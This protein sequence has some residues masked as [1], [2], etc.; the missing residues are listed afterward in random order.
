MRQRLIWLKNLS[1]LQAGR[2]VFN[3]TH[4][5]ELL[6]RRQLA[7]NP[8]AGL[9]DFCRYGLRIHARA[10]AGGGAGSEQADALGV[11]VFTEKDCARLHR[12][13]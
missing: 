9:K 11:L 1:R 3:Q 4:D 2:L 8:V 12:R 7:A 10:E 5:F 6:Q 13:K